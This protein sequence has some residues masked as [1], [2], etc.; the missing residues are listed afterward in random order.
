[1]D[2]DAITFAVVCTTIVASVASLVA[3]G[4]AARLLLMRAKRLSEHPPLEDSR[5]RQLQESI[6]AIAV[7]VERIS[8][9]QRFTTKLLADRERAER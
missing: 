4:V 5:V 7:E 9:A 8:E 1:M 3:I 2:P 6:D